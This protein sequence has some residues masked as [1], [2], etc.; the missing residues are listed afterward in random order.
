M[1]VT[2]AIPAPA[3]PA[4]PD[5]T[6]TGPCSRFSRS[7]TGQSQPSPGPAHTGQVKTPIC[8]Q[9]GIEFPLFAFSH[10]RDVVAAVTNAGG[11]GR[12]GRR[13]VPAGSAEQ[14]L[15]WIDDHV[16]GKPYGVDIIVPA[17]YEGRGRTSP[18]I[19]SPSASR[20]ASRFIN[21]L[22]ARTTSNSRRCGS[23]PRRCRQHRPRTARGF[24]EAPDQTD[25]QRA[26]RAPGLHDRHGQGARHSCRCTRRRQGARHQQ[27]RAGV[28]LI[29]AQGTEAGGHCARSAPWC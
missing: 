21:E 24:A 16:N 2:S 20:R 4:T 29:V 10:R 28:D 23:R 13:R 27:V 7:I 14:E 11:L 12:V 3:R 26:W 9:Y 5:R 8:E 17:K 1:S 18:A 25:G 22:L 6:A 19:N 15:C